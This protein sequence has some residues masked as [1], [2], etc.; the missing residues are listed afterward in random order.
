MGLRV[1]A[2][3][4]KGRAL[5]APAGQE[6]R[7]TAARVKE[8]LFSI[9]G[10]RVKVPWVLD[11][12]AG[13]GALAIE[14]L[15]RGSQRAVL[16]EKSR[17]AQAAIRRNVAACNLQTRLFLLCADVLRVLA[18]PWQ[19]WARVLPAETMAQD[20]RF[21]LVFLDPPYALDV[22]GPVLEHLAAG[23]YLESGAMVVAEHSRHQG[24]SPPPGFALLRQSRYGETMVSFFCFEGETH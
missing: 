3:E 5:W 20:A 12:Y 9:L 14:A 22:L 19:S 15:S 8:S 17:K 11:L 7:P 1:I 21:G 16:V 2:G 24:L 13:S 6:T 23:Q 10:D 18:E 4:L